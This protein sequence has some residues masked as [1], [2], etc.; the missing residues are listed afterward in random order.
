MKISHLLC[1]GED[2]NLRIEGSP[3]FCWLVSGKG[4]QTAYRLVISDGARCVY[5]GGKIETS[6]NNCAVDCLLEPC[7]DYVAS[8]TVYF[9]NGKSDEKSIKFRTALI[10]GFCPE[11]KWIRAAENNP[12]GGGNPVSYFRKKFFVDSFSRAFVYCAGLGLYDITLNGA[13]VTDDVLKEP[14]TCYSEKI[15]Y[16]VYEITHLLKRGENVVELSLAD[17]WYNQNVEDTWGFWKADWKGAN[18]FILQMQIDDELIVSDESWEA[19][20]DGPISRSAFRLGEVCDLRKTPSYSGHAILSEIPKSRLCTRIGHGI[21]EAEKITYRKATLLPSGVLLDFGRNISGYVSLTTDGTDGESL[22]VTYGERLNDGYIDNRSNARYILDEKLR[23]V[24][25][26]DFVTLKSGVNTFKPKFVYYG[27]RYVFIE[28]LKQIPEKQDVVAYFVHTGFSK[29]GSV[30]TD[31]ER[32]NRLQRM[33]LDSDMANFVGIPTDCPHREKNGWSG[34]IGVSAEQFLYNFD[35]GTDLKKWIFDML[36]CQAENGAFACIAPTARNIFGYEWGTGPAWD[37][38]VFELTYQLLIRCGDYKTLQAAY[39]H[40]VKYFDYLETRKD[41][42]GTVC[43]GLGDWFYPLDKKMKVAPTRLTDTLY[44]YRMARY[45]EF[46]GN[47]L[48]GNDCGYRKRAEDIKAAADRAFLKPDGHVANDAITALAAYLYFF[49]LDKETDEKITKRLVRAIRNKKYGSFFGIL[50]NK[51]LHRVLFK[52]GFGDISVR[53][54]ESDE[55]PSFGWW[56][57][58]G[59]VSLLEDYEDVLS[60]N[61]H[62]FGDISAVFYSCVVGADYYVFDGMLYLQVNIPKL[63]SIS[64][65]KGSFRTPNGKVSVEWQKNQK[66][67][68]VKLSLPSGT[69]ATVVCGKNSRAVFSE[70][71]GNYTFNF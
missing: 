36:D 32:I 65:A 2:Y 8:L 49:E 57:K 34:D 9:A 64:H 43:F 37:F 27:F 52:R 55:Y 1:N 25:Q 61:H 7:T 26:K 31:N 40:L 33:T 5:D 66:G 58:R 16:G 22:T 54:W 44:A 3:E 11:A 70:G 42:D 50:G 28:G 53:I 46:F 63:K 41:A 59:N 4:F 12:T 51:Y 30:V 13:E 15:F 18:K 19:C 14:Y 23:E 39:P 62:M 38:A 67:Y 6:K 35:V 24:Y 71:V 60:R 47:R 21:K 17:G 69:N 68:F 56:I 48:F 45:L 29:T 20:T 10:N